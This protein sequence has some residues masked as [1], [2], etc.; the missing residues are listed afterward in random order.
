MYVISRGLVLYG[1]HVLRKGSVWG[2]DVILENPQVHLP[3]IARA[4][5][6]TDVNAMYR[7][8]SGLEYAASTATLPQLSAV[9]VAEKDGCSSRSAAAPA[10]GS[11]KSWGPS[12]ERRNR[13][14]APCFSS[15]CGAG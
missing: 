11:S 9:I 6:F 14:A 12:P 13:C 7:G 2:E 1:M 10:S 4:M 8:G 3:F 5:Q 15:S